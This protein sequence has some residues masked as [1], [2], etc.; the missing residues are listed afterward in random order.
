MKFYNNTLTDLVKRIKNNQIKSLLLH[1][2]NQGFI[3]ATIKKIAKDLDLQISEFDYKDITAGKLQMLANNQNF[4]GSKELIKIS[5]TKTSIDKNIKELLTQENFHNF[6]CF[7]SED[8]LPASGIRKFFEDRADL[9]SLGSYFDN[10]QTVARIILQQCTK[11]GKTIKEEALSYLK[12]HLQG[13]HQIIKSELDKLLFF[14]HDK[15]V[16]TKEDVLQVLSHDLSASGDEMCVF[17]AKKDPENFLKEIAKLQEQGKNEVLMIR[18]LIRY[19]LN[20]YTVS[21]KLE[22]GTNIEHAIKTL[23][24]PIFFKYVD[25]FKQAVRKYNAKDALQILQALQKAEV[26]YKTTPQSFDLFKTYLECHEL[27]E[28]V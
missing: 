9:A 2:P 14:T 1:G 27:T 21:L 20:I 23:Y 6:I 19:F 17:F 28:A 11:Y 8:S 18:A 16:I 4:F 22:E 12:S 13:D 24:P 5:K 3:S 26:A 7:I 25:D 15:Q 10:E